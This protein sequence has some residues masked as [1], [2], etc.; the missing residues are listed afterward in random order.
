VVVGR[1]GKPHGLKGEFSVLPETDHPERFAVGSRVFVRAAPAE[2]V[3]SRWIHDRLFVG[4]DIARTRED[5][6]Q[7]RSEVIT[8]P[9]EQRRQLDED[10][11]WPD[12]LVGLSVVDADGGVRGEVVSIVE[13]VAQDRLVVSTPAGTV[14]IPFVEE[15]VPTV[16]LEAGRIVLGR[17]GG[18]FTES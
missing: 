13:G 2:V 17:V 14:E 7:L 16:D 9:E 6:E 4:L 10:E 3:S 12:Q 18:L 1:I 5:A 15:L 8:I 11:W